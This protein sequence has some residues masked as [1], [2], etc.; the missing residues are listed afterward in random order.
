VTA[1]G[2]DSTG[3]RIENSWGTFWGASGYATLS[4]AFV[5][6]Y[7]DEA[8]SIGPLQSTAPPGTAPA[9]TAPPTISG[10]ATQGQTLTATAGS[11][12]PAGSSYTYQWQRSAN[13]GATWGV[14]A[15]ATA[16]SYV[17]AQGDVGALLRVSVTA[18]GSAGSATANSA[19]TGTVTA[20]APQNTA[21]PA[22]YGLSRQGETLSP[23]PGRGAPCQ[24]RTWGVGPVASGAPQN[25]VRP[26][27]SGTARSGQTL[28]VSTGSWSPAAST[29]AFQWQSST[30]GR[31]TWANIT[32]AGARA[33]R[34]R[35][36]APAPGSEPE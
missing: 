35:A 36:R 10:T 5:N 8:V 18:W 34:C 14:I 22:V 6:G 1:L 16:A 13:D 17:I 19:A 33:T 21:R 20:V 23:R 32:G 7:V 3:L 30:D 29:F 27:I 4:W 9:N 15:G 25:T 12:S 2:Y 24:A 28:R 11:W 31:S 26:A